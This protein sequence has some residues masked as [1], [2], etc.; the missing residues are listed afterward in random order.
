VE[1]KS[2][3]SLC[4]RCWTGSFGPR[5]RREAAP[6]Q[7]R[8]NATGGPRPGS[9]SRHGPAADAK[10][11]RSPQS[12]VPSAGNSSRAPPRFPS[13]CGRRVNGRSVENRRLD[14]SPFPTE[15]VTRQHL[16]PAK[17][18]CLDQGNRVSLLH[19]AAW[20]PS[21]LAFRRWCTTRRAPQML[22][23]RSIR[24]PEGQRRLAPPGQLQAEPGLVAAGPAGC[25]QESGSPVLFGGLP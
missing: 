3:P 4:C 17:L 12:D 25:G 11:R 1:G 19:R 7:N 8:R 2:R 16:L 13:R 21:V 23:P 10:P 24:P 9:Q 20:Q 6:A 5:T 14:S 18:L 15:K 22:P